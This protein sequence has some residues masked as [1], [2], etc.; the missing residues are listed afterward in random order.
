[1]RLP[2]QE[3]TELDLQ[4]GD[5]FIILASDGLW[6]V[7][8]DQAAVDF[9]RERLYGHC[10]ALGACPYAFAVRAGGSIVT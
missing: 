9:V 3:V 8:T 1:M 6:Q 7:M 4:R 10:C 5:E 2:L